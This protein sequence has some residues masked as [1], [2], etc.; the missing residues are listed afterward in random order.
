[1]AD[2]KTKQTWQDRERVAGEQA[3]EL[4]YFADK[5]GIGISKA[6]DLIGND[7]ATLGGEAS[8]IA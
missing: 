6:R 8:K 1:M 3:Y 5:H 2:D 7:R 4:Q